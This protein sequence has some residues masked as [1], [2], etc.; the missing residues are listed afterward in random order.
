MDCGVIRIGSRVRVRDEE[1]DAEFEI[2]PHEEA[3]YAAERVSAASPLGRAL[4]GHRQGDDVRFRAPAGLLA[5]VV[6]GVA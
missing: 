4:L 5:V 3:D 2:V 1:G 6:V